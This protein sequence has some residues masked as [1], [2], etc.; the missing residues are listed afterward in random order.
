MSRFNREYRFDMGFAVNGN[1]LP[2]PATYGG[3]ENSLD[4]KA[5]RDASGNLHREMVATKHTYKMGWR[6]IEWQMISDILSYVRGEEFDFTA[7]DPATGENVTR[8]CYAGDR[9]WDCVWSPAGEDSLGN[10]NFNVIEY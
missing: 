2:D 10:L 3:T 7:P 1:P 8:K 6:N 5:E 4:T 9:T